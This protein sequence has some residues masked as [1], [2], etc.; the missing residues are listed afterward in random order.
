MLVRLQTTLLNHKK[1]G[2]KIFKSVPS[3]MED[4]TRHALIQKAPLNVLVGMD[5]LLQQII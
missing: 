3:T 4:V 5:T 1:F 2:T